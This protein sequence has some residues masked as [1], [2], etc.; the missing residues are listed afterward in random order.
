MLFKRCLRDTQ[1]WSRLDPELSV[2][3]SLEKIVVW[4]RGNGEADRA[5]LGDG[6]EFFR[7]F[8]GAEEF[9]FVHDQPPAEFW[10]TAPRIV[11]EQTRALSLRGQLVA[12]L[13]LF[14]FVT[15][16]TIQGWYILFYLERYLILS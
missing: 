11:V 6:H 3:N 16:L 12:P 7:L 2:P 10:T 9:E 8:S 15:N 4:C 14:R 13:N 1:Y 5:A